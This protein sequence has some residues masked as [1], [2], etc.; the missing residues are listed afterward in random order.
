MA[1]SPYAYRF[2]LESL[3]HTNTDARSITMPRGTVARKSAEPKPDGSEQRVLNLFFV[4]NASAEPLTTEQIIT[5][6][7][8]GYGGGNLES[9]KKKFQRDRKT[10]AEH[11]VIVREV[12]A[13][14][15]KKTDESAWTIDR[16]RTFAAGGLIT[17][18]DADLL[19]SAIDQALS[20]ADS[21]LAA[22]LESIRDKILRISKGA[23]P[24][25]AAVHTPE[26]DAVWNAFATRRPLKF[27]YTNA[28][29]ER[30][31]RTANIYGVFERGGQ[32]YFCGLDDATGTIRT[33]RC[34]RI[35]RAK[36]G[37]GT[38]E[39]PADFRLRDRVFL[40][41]DFSDE[42]PIGASFTLPASCSAEQVAGITLG[43]GLCELSS[44]AWTWNVDVRDIPAAASFCLEH[45]AEGL[46]PVAPAELVDTWRHDIER[47]VAAHA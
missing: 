47:T 2:L 40:P 29:G 12:R 37:S 23:A 3:Q 17:A 25:P 28:Q 38:Y 11:G 9:D 34:D 26:T 45:A 20:A 41:F 8:L 39:V 4:L 18:D 1:Q 22:P 44:D 33:F 7:D 15:A 27:T 42:E 19:A 36:R 32:S 43:R 16:E 5:D 10:L 21:P 30:R 6:S 31:E 14:G 24:A 46:R 13:E 35:V